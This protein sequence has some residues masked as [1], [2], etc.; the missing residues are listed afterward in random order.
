MGGMPYETTE[1]DIH[2]LFGECGAVADIEMA[3]FPDSGR[4]KGLAFIT[5]KVR[6]HEILINH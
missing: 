3:T 2:A 6:D 1:D 5:F 4:F